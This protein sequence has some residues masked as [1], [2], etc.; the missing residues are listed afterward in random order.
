MNLLPEGLRILTDLNVTDDVVRVVRWA[1]R[2]SQ[3]GCRTRGP[4]RSARQLTEER[5][6]KVRFVP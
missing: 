5:P 1:K 6:T 4:G 2:G 3:R